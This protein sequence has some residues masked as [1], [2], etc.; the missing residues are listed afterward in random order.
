[1]KREWLALTFAMVFPTAIAL[2]Y[3][4]ALTGSAS[5]DGN[6][7]MQAAY[8]GGKI[9]QFLFPVVYLAVIGSG[10]KVR[11]PHFAGLFWGLAFGLLTAGLILGIYTSELSRLFLT[12]S[13]RDLVRQKVT[14]MAGG[15]T[16]LR[17]LAL[18]TFLSVAHSLL[19]EYYWRWFVF[20]RLRN[21]MPAF[22][23]AILSSIAFMGHHVVVLD[24]YLPNR[25][26]TATVPLSL[27]IAAGGGVWCWLFHK[28]GSVY[29]PWLSHMIVDAAIMAVGYELLFR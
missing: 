17:Y 22:A 10:L 25:F 7:A 23:A 8:G 1:V 14:A 18:A 13:T 15:A 27:G 3:F 29:S 19:E 26:W 2:T 4:L 11:R 9:V 5:G 6:P 21:L 16:P 28:T 20:G 24:V 12:P